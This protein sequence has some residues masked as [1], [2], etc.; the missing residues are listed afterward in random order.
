MKFADNE[1]E[2]LLNNKTENKLGL[3]LVVFFLCLYILKRVLVKEHIHI[4]S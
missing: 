1:R 2:P 4:T 3:L